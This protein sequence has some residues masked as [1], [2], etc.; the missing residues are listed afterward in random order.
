MKKILSSIASG[1]A[2]SQAFV[3]NAFAKLPDSTSTITG[4][5][6]STDIKQG[7]ADIIR[8]VLD[9]ILIIAVVYVIVA[10]IRL[11]VSGGEEAEKDKSKTTII[12]VIVGIVIVLFA[13][14]IVVS[15]NNAFGN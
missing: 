4:L 11:I 1:I 8:Q 10:G 9:F 5:Q 2:L 3:L 6:T 12:Y 7:I 15:I 13:R 14:V